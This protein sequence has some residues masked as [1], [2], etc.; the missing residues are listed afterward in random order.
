MSRSRHR[1][2]HPAAPEPPGRR[3]RPADQVVLVVILLIAA[4]L[5]VAGVPTTATVELLAGA[6]AVAMQVLRVRP[7]QASRTLRLR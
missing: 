3:L 2:T 1:P 5:A 4:A 7:D 6:G